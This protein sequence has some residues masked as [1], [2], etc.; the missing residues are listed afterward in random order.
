MRRFTSRPSSSAHQLAGHLVDGEHGRHR[1][2]TLHGFHD[3]VM[4]LDILL[5]PRFQQYNAG[6]HPLGVG[7]HRAGL[8]AE[9]LGLVTGGKAT[10][11]VG[12]HGHNAH[13]TAAQLGPKILLHRG[14]IG[15]QI[16]KQPVQMR[17]ALRRRIG[18]GRHTRFIFAFSSLIGKR[19]MPMLHFCAE[20]FLPRKRL[21]NLC[22][23][24]TIQ[25]LCFWSIFFLVN[26]DA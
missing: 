6:T 5:V 13:R 25:R 9:G 8:H 1:Q 19:K 12:H 23:V 4:V 10:G 18:A 7:H 20:E 11:C 3:A 22:V 16:D 15:V 24:E 26:D 2:A 21:Q 17:A 14:K